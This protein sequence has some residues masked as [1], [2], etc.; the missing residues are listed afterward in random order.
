MF[1]RLATSNDF[2]LLLEYVENS[3]YLSFTDFDL[4]TQLL[5]FILKLKSLNDISYLHSALLLVIEES[6]KL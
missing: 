5:I 6:L 1:S 4:N 2:M 3:S